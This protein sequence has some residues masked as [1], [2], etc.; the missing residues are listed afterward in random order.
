MSS[1]L[2]E[3]HHAALRTRCVHDHIASGAAKA[4][5]PDFNKLAPHLHCLRLEEPMDH[6]ASQLRTSTGGR[7]LACFGGTA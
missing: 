4:L 3:Q 6:A 7:A 5:R 2:I 1:H